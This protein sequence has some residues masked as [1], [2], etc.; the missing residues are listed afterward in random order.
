MLRRD[1]NR[2]LLKYASRDS[3]ELLGRGKGGVHEARS[4]VASQTE[5]SPLYGLIVYRR[6]R[7]LIKYIPEGTSRVLLGMAWAETIASDVLI[8]CSSDSGS[9]ARCP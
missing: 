2:F 9:L 1:K 4:V 3:V 6:R 8:V 7:V 5:K